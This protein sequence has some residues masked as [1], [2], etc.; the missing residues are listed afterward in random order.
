M[1]KPYQHQDRR[2]NQG[3]KNNS[4]EFK[5][6]FNPEWISQG[7]N[8]EMI[9]FCDELGKFLKEYRVSASQLRNIYGEIM[10]IKL[11]GIENEKEAFWL[12]K[13]KLA[14]NAARIEKNNE[15]DAFKELIKK[16]LSPAMDAVNVNE[17]KTFDHFQKF[18][19][20]ILAYHKYHGGK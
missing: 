13:P 12:L 4:P 11:K 9:K 3:N 1:N 18:F 17:K 2:N 20:A 10:R 15:K 16:A 5:M 7:A 6:N 14:Y 19:E 8:K